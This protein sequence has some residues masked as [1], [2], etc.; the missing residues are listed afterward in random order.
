MAEI[1]LYSDYCAKLSPHCCLDI[2]LT[3]LNSFCITHNPTL[4]F[5][6]VL[7]LLQLM[8]QAVHVDSGGMFQ[9]FRILPSF[10]MFM[11]HP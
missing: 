9:K 6:G 11:F 1:S 2:G 10:H 5:A 4:M 3:V 8:Q 7:C